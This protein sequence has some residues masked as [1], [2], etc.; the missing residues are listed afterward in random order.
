MTDNP[1]SSSATVHQLQR[2]PNG[3][4]APGSGGRVPGSK[5][6]VSNAALA[7]VRDMK[8]AAIQQL[9]EKLIA[10]DWQ[11]VLFVLER[12]LPKGR[13]IELDAATPSAITGALINGTITSE[14]AKNVATVLEKVASI[15]QVTELRERLEALERLQNA[16]R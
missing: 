1:A 5:N 9:R 4:F 7:A 6:L 3:Q 11:A 16:A 15:E 10:G 2:L 12:C 13:P 8:D 14:E